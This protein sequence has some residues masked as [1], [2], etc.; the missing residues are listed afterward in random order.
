MERADYR[1]EDAGTS[2]TILS[3]RALKRGVPM[4]WTIDGRLAVGSTFR[5]A[6]AYDVAFFMR[7]REAEGYTFERKK[8]LVSVETVF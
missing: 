7:L 5:F 8:E 3:E 6:T 2:V 1:I 4:H